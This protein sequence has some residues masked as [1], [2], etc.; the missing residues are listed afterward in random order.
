MKNVRMG[1]KETLDWI[2]QN[3]DT[4]WLHD[5]EPIAS[6]TATLVADIFQSGNVAK[7]TE[8]LIKRLTDE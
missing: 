3:D 7:V 1:Y 4:E 5:E 2:I 6:V 8:D